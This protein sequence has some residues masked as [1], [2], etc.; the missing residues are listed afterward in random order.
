M[1]LKYDILAQ[2]QKAILTKP[3]KVVQENIIID[4]E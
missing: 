3:N 1:S 2:G 4:C